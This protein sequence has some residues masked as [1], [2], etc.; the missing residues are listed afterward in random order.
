MMIVDRDI[1]GTIIYKSK[2][3]DLLNKYKK[4]LKKDFVF[5]KIK[6][7]SLFNHLYIACSKTKEGQIFIDNLNNHILDIRNSVRKDTF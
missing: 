4:E 2:L 6:E 5:L 7:L 3:D 1:D